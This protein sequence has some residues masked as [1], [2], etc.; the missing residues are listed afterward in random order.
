MNPGWGDGVQAAKAGLL[1]IGDVFVVNKADRD[2]RRRRPCT[3]SRAMLDLGGSAPWRRPVLETVATDDRGVDDAA[4]TRS[5]A[6]GH[7]EGVGRARANAANS[8]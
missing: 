1:E 4:S 7:L 5:V 3:T 2:G 6:T 8:A